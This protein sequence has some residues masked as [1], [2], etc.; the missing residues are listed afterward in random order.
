MAAMREALRSALTTSA[1]GFA[2]V[3]AALT[4]KGKF[5]VSNVQLIDRGYEKLEE[6]L[7]LLG[8]DVEKEIG[9]S[10]AFLFILR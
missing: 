9:L 4:G 8:A 5:I 7:R 1:P 2:A 10:M 6:R 3:T